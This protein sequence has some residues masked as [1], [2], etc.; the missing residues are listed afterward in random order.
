MEGLTEARQAFFLNANKDRTPEGVGKVY[1]YVSRDA[2]INRQY[3]RDVRG[4]EE[5]MSPDSWTF[6]PLLPRDGEGQEDPSLE[7]LSGLLQ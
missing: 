2:I 7:A 4:K 6:R 5:I 3:L 1:D